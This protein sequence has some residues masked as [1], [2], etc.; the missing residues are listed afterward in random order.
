MHKGRKKDIGELQSLIGS[1]PFYWL[2]VSHHLKIFT[3]PRWTIRV[4]CIYGCIKSL[5]SEEY[6]SFIYSNLTG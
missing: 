2:E 1:C 6:G 5:K 4:V 3:P